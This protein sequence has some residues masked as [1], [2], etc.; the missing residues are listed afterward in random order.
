VLYNLARLPDFQ[1]DLRTE[2][3]AAGPLDTVDY[4]KMPL[5]NAVINV[6]S[7][8]ASS[9]FIKHWWLILQ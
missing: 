1:R 5:L 9:V 6:R 7:L 4:E 8:P 2:I 3:Q